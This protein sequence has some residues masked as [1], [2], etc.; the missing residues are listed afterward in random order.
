MSF[1]NDGLGT[2]STRFLRLQRPPFVAS[3]WY[4]AMHISQWSPVV[5]SSHLMHLFDSSHLEWPLHWHATV[6]IIIQF[7][8][9]RRMKFHLKKLPGQF[10]KFQFAGSQAFL[11]TKLPVRL[12]VRGPESD[13]SMHIPK[14][15]PLPKSHH[16]QNGEDKQV[17]HEVIS[18][19][20]K[21][22][23]AIIFSKNCSY[24]AVQ[25]YAK[26]SY[27]IWSPWNGRSL[28]VETMTCIAQTGRRQ[29][30]H[31]CLRTG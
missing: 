10:V 17:S 19:H 22:N 5:K 27:W 29:R 3:P 28:D 4:P 12:T 8:T 1:I 14:P 24:W 21:Q 23:Y 2:W 6:E 13:P 7:D 25:S 11:F 30:T 20:S 9:T 16:P 15:V 18:V 26:C 31:F